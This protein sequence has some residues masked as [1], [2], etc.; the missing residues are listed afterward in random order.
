MWYAGVD[1]ADSHHDIV[2]I[3]EM[4]HRLTS[5]RVMHT[6]EGLDELTS[7]LTHICGQE[8]KAEL[9]CII[10]T[11][12]GLL[13]TNLL[14]AG[15]A[16]YPVNPKTVDHKRSASGAKTDKIDAYLLAKH[17]RSEFTDLRRLEPDSPL[18]AE[19]KA[20]TR[21]QD[22]LIQMQTR[23]V[24]QLT[25]CLKA[26]YPVALLLFSQVQQPSTLLFLQTYPTPLEAMRATPQQI[27]VLLKTTRHPTA[28]KTA[29]HI[30]EQLHQ[31][32]LS[33]DEITTRTKSR[34]LLVLIRQ[35]QPVME[36]ITTYDQEILRLFLA[37]ADSHLFSTLPR[38]GK[39]L[40]PRLLAEFGD[41][42]S[43]Y[44]DATSLQALAGTSPVPYES[45][46]Y[47][48]PHRRYACIKP[49]RNV[50][51]QFARA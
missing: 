34:L 35:L 46:S 10:E 33:A 26:Y 45:G 29:T 1:W 50:L 25:A 6:P 20:L 47:A 40:A 15:F 51:Q 14:E 49:L 41:D 42:R 22:G 43:R 17:G 30:V 12:H 18:I 38:A 9:A 36:A 11:N 32:F 39:R 19:L 44:R 27:A 13:I 2:V 31:P 4:G 37:H 5:F 3:D 21:D 28:E 24:N 23:L 48:K 8:H 16:V 7:R